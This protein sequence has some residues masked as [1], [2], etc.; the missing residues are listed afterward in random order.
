MD[1]PRRQGTDNNEEHCWVVCGYCDIELELDDSELS[2]GWYTCPECGQLSHL[3]EADCETANP[4]FQF[5]GSDDNGKW[6]QVAE[7]AGAEEATLEVSYLRANGIEAFAWQK[8]GQA[9]DLTG[10]GM[11]A[12]H[13]MVRTDQEQKALSIRGNL[14]ECEHCRESLAI[15]DQEVTQEWFVCP[16]CQGTCYLSDTI[17]CLSCGSQLDLG[18]AVQ[19]QGWHRCPSCDRLIPMTPLNKLVECGCCGSNLELSDQ[20]AI[21]GWFVC[22]LCCNMGYLGG[23]VTC[24]SCGNRK[25]LGKAEWQQGWYYCPR[26]E[27]IT[28][29]VEE[30]T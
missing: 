16:V 28:H 21:Q 22:P 15:S 18:Q 12:F 9:F 24:L 14:V 3:T 7:M 25:D 1:E 5:P 11:G 6:V 17:T 4:V 30:V 2:R 27:Q 19:E 29:L 23:P 13:V 26:C 10:G 20:E 8:G